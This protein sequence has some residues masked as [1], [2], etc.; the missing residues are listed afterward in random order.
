[1]E[2]DREKTVN[3]KNSLLLLLVCLGVTR[4]QALIA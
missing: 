1:V 3:L 2:G 4:L